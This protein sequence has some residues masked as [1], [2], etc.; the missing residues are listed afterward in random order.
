MYA[1]TALAVFGHTTISLQAAEDYGIDM[2]KESEEY[3]W[4]VV[5][6]TL[7]FEITNDKRGDGS[8][9]EQPWTSKKKT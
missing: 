7:S 8:Y 1:R 3:G 9:R 4:H 6:H 2:A 5:K